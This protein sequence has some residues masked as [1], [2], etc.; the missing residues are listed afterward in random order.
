MLSTMPD[1]AAFDF[2]GTLTEGGSVFAFLSAVAGRRAV[3]A[4][5]ASL[6][7]AL[8]R[9]AVSGGTAA[10]RAKEQLFRRVLAGVEVDRLDEVG[11][12]FAEDHLTGHLRHD[13]HARFLWHQRRGDRLVIVSASPEAY[14]AHAGRILGADHVVATRLA[15]EDGRLTGGYEGRNCRGEEKLR[16]LEEWTAGLDGPP[17]R[18][19][20]YG[21]SRGDLRMLGAADVGVNVGRLGA[22]GRLRAYPGL[23]AVPTGAGG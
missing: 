6:S 19:W 8:V 15:V 10:D 18:L 3:T 12:R 1:T 23:D 4:A 21:N 9:A 22:V 14:L 11:R 2:D 13:V 17:G 20:A 7:P 16:R 5:S